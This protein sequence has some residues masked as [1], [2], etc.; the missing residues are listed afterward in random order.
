MEQEP[1]ESIAV[2][3]EKTAGC[4]EAGRGPLA[5]NVIAAAVI[6]DPRKP[7][8]GL[9]DSKKLSHKQRESLYE[10]ILSK[11]LGVGIGSAS[12]QE[13]DDINILQASLLAMTRA[14]ESLPTKP[15]FV[16]VDGNRCPRWSFPSL[17]VVKGDAKVASISAASIVAKVVR[18]RE[19]LLL[20]E[21]YPGYGFAQHKGYPTAAHFAALE[22]L[23]ATPVHR[24]S[25]APVAARVKR[26]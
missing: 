21:Q 15:E 14:V 7:I 12:P 1:W 16:F 23:G 3:P 10:T 18:D 5:G 22:S 13:I 9:A 24:L 4:D 2:A 8:T 11:A 25:F 17:A 19:L 20:D 6:L 26:G